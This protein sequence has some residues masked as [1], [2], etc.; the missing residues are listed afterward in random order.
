MKYLNLKY[1]L[2]Q[3]G[4]EN[5]VATYY[6]VV[7]FSCLH[8]LSPLLL[9]IELCQICTASIA[10]GPIDGVSTLSWWWGLSAP[11]TLRAMPAV[12]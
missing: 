7:V 5:F 11:E 12:A 4:G 3:S 6:F 2:Y 9:T 8:F 10:H 1:Q